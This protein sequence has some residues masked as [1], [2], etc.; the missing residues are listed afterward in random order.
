MQT[1]TLNARRA[2]SRL[3]RGV[4]PG[5]DI[6][7]IA[8]G[9]E[10]LESST[11][12]LLADDVRPRWFAVSG[13][14]GEGKSFF[15]ALSSEI[16]LNAGYAVVVLDINKDTGALNHPQRH[17]PL[18]FSS[19]QSPIPGFRCHQGL[20]EILRQWLNVTPK[21]EAISI[22]KRIQRVVPW[23]NVG[24]DP[25]VLSSLI[26]Q[27]ESV[28]KHDRFVTA[29]GLVSG[30]GQGVIHVDAHGN[31]YKQGWRNDVY[32]YRLG[33]SQWE[34]F[35]PPSAWPGI[36]ARLRPLA[37]GGTTA[38]N[39]T[40]RPE[41]VTG[42]LSFLTG[43]DLQRKG[44]YARF[45]TGY[46]FQVIQEWC[47]ATGHKGLLLFIDEL[48]NVVRQ[49]H[50]NAHAGCFRTLAWYCSCPQL[51]NTRVI[52]AG[53]PE[54]ITMLDRGGRRQYLDILKSQASLRTE[55]LKIYERWKREADALAEAG[56]EHCATLKPSQRIKLFDRIAKI[57]A[58]A[59]GV[60][61]APDEQT[62]ATLARNPQFN[63]TRRWVRAIVQTLDILEQKQQPFYRARKPVWQMTLT[64]WRELRQSLQD[65]WNRT[66]DGSAEAALR[67]IGG[68]TTDYAHKYRVNE[69]LQQGLAVP[70]FVLAEYPDLR[71]PT[72]LLA[73]GDGVGH[74]SAS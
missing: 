39:E 57:H 74:V 63:T 38:S 4:P 33:S 69:A 46:R 53:T 18:L 60:T 68:L 61:V 73:N 55:E 10:R 9:M 21:T 5:T 22:L 17:L 70:S 64:E 49:I 65:R 42:L 15:Q 37:K 36:L 59:W 13:E 12:A 3:K 16:A 14:Y 43:H 54:I 2:L 31:Y 27:L 20:E 25:L 62:I 45:A 50:V 29:A 71:P 72:T 7:D 30:D 19:M 28:E 66:K 67:E 32:V 44:T 35:A 56:W 11:R 6:A 40:S 1:D 8:V 48:D 23:S 52:F 26:A 34:Y 41:H 51:A 58:S 47:L 24:Q